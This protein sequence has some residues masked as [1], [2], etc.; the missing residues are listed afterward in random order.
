VPRTPFIGLNE[1]GLPGSGIIYSSSMVAVDD[2]LRIYSSSSKHLHMQ[3]GQGFFQPKGKIPA[4]AMLMHTL[5]KYGFMYLASI[6]NWATFTLK[7][8]VLNR[9]DLVM[10][11]QAPLGEVRVQLSD[12]NGEP[13]PGFRFDDCTP[14]K[15]ADATGW[16]ISWQGKSPSGWLGKPMRLEVTFRN[17][18]I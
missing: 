7:P 10:N 5:R 16:A 8:M 17:A 4:G 13:F 18:R 6:G 15:E 9:A 14:L 1:P 3:Y 2:E 11:A 12:M